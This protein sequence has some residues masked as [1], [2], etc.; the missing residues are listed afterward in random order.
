ML[1][2]HWACIDSKLNKVQGILQKIMLEPL[3]FTNIFFRYRN[4]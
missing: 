2:L 4:K 1:Y 3:L